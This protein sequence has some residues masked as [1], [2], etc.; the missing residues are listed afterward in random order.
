MEPLSNRI[1]GTGAKQVRLL[2]HG[3][4]VRQWELRLQLQMAEL[5]NA[6]VVED[7]DSLLLC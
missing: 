2:A 3:N 4:V 7:A 5:D 1:R 6:G